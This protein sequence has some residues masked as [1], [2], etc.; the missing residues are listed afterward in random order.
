MKMHP[1]FQYKFLHSTVS[2]KQPCFQELLQLVRVLAK[3]AE[4]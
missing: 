2:F 3:E 1:Y 4:G